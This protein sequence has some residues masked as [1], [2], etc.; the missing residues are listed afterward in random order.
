MQGSWGQHC[1]ILSWLSLCCGG[2]PVDYRI[3]SGILSLYPSNTTSTLP[4]SCDDRKCLQT[5][6]SVPCGA[7]LSLVENQCFRYSFP[8]IWAPWSS[9]E[10]VKML[11]AQ[12]CPTLCNPMDC[13]PPDSSVYGS[14]QARILE[15]VAMPSSRGSSRP[16]DQTQV[17]H[18]AGR[19]FTI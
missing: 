12:L 17:S 16:R 6:P 9:C 11:V 5:L 4:P 8:F 13:S 10:N 18:I 14:L 1:D 2:C 19:F 7:K 3:S 15:W